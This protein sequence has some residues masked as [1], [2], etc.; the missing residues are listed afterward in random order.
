M[1]KTEMGR[2]VRRAILAPS[3]H[4]TQPWSFVSTRGSVE[5]YADNTRKLRVL[6]PRGRQLVISCGCALFNIRVAL[7]AAGYDAKVERFPD[8]TRP[9]LLARVSLPSE[10]S[11]WLTIG[12]LDASIE[13]RRTNRRRFFDDPVP[14]HVVEDLVQAAK[15]EGAEL[16]PITRPQHRVAT[17]LLSKQADALENSDPAYRAEL[18]EWTTTDLRRQDGVLSVSVPRLDPA[19][20][21]GEDLPIRDFD[22]RGNAWLPG[23]VESS[24]NQCLLLLG[25]H[26]DVPAGW[27][28][29]GEAL[30]RVWLELTHRG[31]VASP[32]TQIIEVAGTHEAL[33]R[34]LEL[35]MHPNVL[36]R[37]G[38]APD[39]PPSGRRPVA[40]VLLESS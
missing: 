25:S 4:N 16:F 39:T 13:R 27:L 34:E 7:A 30:Q 29:A 22:V 14:D 40:E 24:M 21:A 18:L 11:S 9:D 17:A 10:A 32:L 36:L 23:R 3:V 19:A 31:Y 5:L 15:A 1:L 28:S 35:S 26:E 37:V 33:R 2:A 6:D 38:R 12:L 8:T 20:R